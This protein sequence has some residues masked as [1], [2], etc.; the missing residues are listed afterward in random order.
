[1]AFFKFRFP[2]QDD[3]AHHNNDSPHE[4]LEA[5]R[6]RVKH[7]LIGSGVLVL[8]AV[9]G[10]PLVFDTQPRPVGLDIPIDIPDK[11]K[12]AVNVAPAPLKSDKKSALVDKN[13]DQGVSTSN[14]QVSNKGSDLTTGSSEPKSS[15]SNPVTATAAIVGSQGAAAPQAV[16]SAASP[17][18]APPPVPLSVPA[19]SKTS[20]GPSSGPNANSTPPSRSS[21]LKNT[22]VNARAALDAKEEIVPTAKTQPSNNKSTASE[23]PAVQKEDRFVIQVGAYSDEQKVKEIREKLEKAGLHTYTQVVEKDGR[24][25]RIR[26]GPFT[27]KEDANRQLQKVKSLNLQPNLLTL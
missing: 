15:P 12:T 13:S 23:A 14:S 27:S 2:G 5:L 7:R 8:I 22:P 19:P 11:S 6:K 26:I 25:I 4:S 18:T 20:V 24:K 10:F 3:Q 21:D 9:I 16:S 1:M 17:A